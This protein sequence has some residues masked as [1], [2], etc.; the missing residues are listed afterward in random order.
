[1][2]KIFLCFIAV[3]L[4]IP[5]ML[6]GCRD[7]YSSVSYG[8]FMYFVRGEDDGNSIAY[9]NGLSEE[10]K[11]KREVVV[12]ST[13]DGYKIEAL[14]YMFGIAEIGELE[15]DSLE[16]LY[17]H[18]YLYIDGPSTF[19]SCPNLNKIVFINVEGYKTHDYYPHNYGGDINLYYCSA[20]QGC[21]CLYVD[22]RN[23]RYAN[24]SY[25][26]N[27]ETAENE[28][29]YW[30]DNFDYGTRI[31]YIPENP[32]REGYTFD[33]WYKE[34]ECVTRWDFERDTLPIQQL[35]ADGEEV[36]QET[37]LYAKWI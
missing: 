17:V 26:Y 18:S 23:G 29:Y 14:S 3:M 4:A 15:S 7:P 2:K 20:Y 35:N 11:R 27:Y 31:E 36:Y 30:V 12:P 19:N 10:G 34:P 8:D 21:D 5:L 1:M 22:G 28:G 9:L 24:I 32:E 25:M 16:T 33:G 37:K 6:S 13:I